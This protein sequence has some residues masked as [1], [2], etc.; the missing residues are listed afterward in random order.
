MKLRSEKDF[1]SGLV[2]LAVGTVF[3]VGALGYGFGSPTAPGPAVLPI[4]FGALTALAGAALLFKSLTLETEG[5][6]RIDALGLRPLLL[7]AAAVVSFGWTLPKLGLLF[8]VPGLVL[9][10][11][12]AVGRV[13][14]RML[15][16][17][18]VVLTAIACVLYVGVL[19]AAA[20]LWT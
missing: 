10:S 18:A 3:A 11:A 7:I 19:H 12:L 8:A 6:E 14:F 13:G 16:L 1:W 5:G 4:G 15:L 2:F 9:F 20:P 17:Q